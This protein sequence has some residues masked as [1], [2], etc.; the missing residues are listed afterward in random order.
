LI[1]PEDKDMVDVNLAT[2]LETGH[3]TYEYR[4]RVA[5]GSY[6]W[7]YDI[8]KLLKSPRGEISYILGTWIDITDHK[9]TENEL[10][11]RV[12]E[13]EKFYEIAIGKE[14]EI[15]KLKKE[16]EKLKSELSQ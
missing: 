12:V 6:K 10:K 7:F 15:S 16:I 2:L 13:L 14:L 8:S 9:K 1:H 5:D 4:W 11:E 3:I